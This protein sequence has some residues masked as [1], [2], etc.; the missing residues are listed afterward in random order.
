MGDWRYSSTYHN[1]GI[2]EDVPG[3]T[4]VNKVLRV[5]A[6]F[7]Y[8][9]SNPEGYPSDLLCMISVT[10]YASFHILSELTT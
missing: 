9:V 4:E 2:D 7:L 8:R 1:H 6:G 3:K 5:L 10:V